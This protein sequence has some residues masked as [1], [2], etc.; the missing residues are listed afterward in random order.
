MPKKITATD[1]AGHAAHLSLRLHPDLIRRADE[2]VPLFAS[3]SSLAPTGLADRA[4]VL[5]R[6]L[7]LGLTHLE[8]D[9]TR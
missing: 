1:K 5:R 6:A 7:E 4:D 3:S 9:L 2:L 8:H